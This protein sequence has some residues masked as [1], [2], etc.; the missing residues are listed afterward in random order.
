MHSLLVVGAYNVYNAVGL[1]QR[2][3][4]FDE[5]ATNES[6]YQFTAQPLVNFVFQDGG[7][8]TVFAYVLLCF[9]GS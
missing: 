5:A 2:W 6:I 9:A 7:H 3:Q 8:A 4:T 1:V